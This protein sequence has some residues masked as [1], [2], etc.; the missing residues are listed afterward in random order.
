MS[1]ALTVK[2]NV[3]NGVILLK[4]NFNEELLLKMD[5]G[6]TIS[7][8]L[9]KRYQE[10]RDR[11]RAKLTTISCVVDINS[12]IAGSPLVRG[13]FELWREV[14]QKDGGQ[15]VC[16]NYPKDYI[17]SLTS[18]GLPALAG[19]NLAGSTEEAIKILGAQ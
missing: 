2:K 3:E 12:E 7:Q 8:E 18:L 14:V 11:D 9:K 1:E 4:V 19:F 5:A 17:D 6:V 15:V 13:L 16:V 10:V